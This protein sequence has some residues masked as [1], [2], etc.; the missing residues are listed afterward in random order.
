LK[1]NPSDELHSRLDA[2]PSS[3][4]LKICSGFTVT[5]QNEACLGDRPQ[6]TGDGVEQLVKMMPGKKSPDK[7]DIQTGGL[8]SQL[9]SRLRAIDRMEL[10]NVNAVPYDRT[11]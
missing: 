10:L 3:L 8:Q 4:R 2:Q 11:L 1:R 6:H 7:S 5:D 9:A